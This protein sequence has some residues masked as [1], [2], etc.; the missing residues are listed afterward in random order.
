MMN[1]DVF[2]I[3]ST[4]TPTVRSTNKTERPPPPLSID[5]IRATIREQP[6][7]IFPE[8]IQYHGLQTMRFL[9]ALLL[10]MS[11]ALVSG[12]VGG[13]DQ[14]LIDENG[15]VHPQ[16]EAMAKKLQSF[17]PV[18]AVDAVELAVLLEAA[19]ADPETMAMVAKFRST[20]GAGADLEAFTKDATPIEIVKG[21]MDALSEIKA[22]EVL[23]QDPERAVVEMHKEGMIDKK[24]FNHYKKNPGDLESETKRGIYF[25]FVAL[26]AAGDFL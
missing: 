19:K 21:M 6:T 23:F 17:A 11:I 18:H 1:T 13:A 8:L 12:Q 24:R 7:A 9:L 25:S 20:E 10:A 4:N 26:A 5:T 22:A 16:Y 3:L 15:N 14:A 2:L